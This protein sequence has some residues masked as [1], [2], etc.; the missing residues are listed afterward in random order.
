MNQTIRRLIATFLTTLAGLT[1][2]S[3]AT[4]A[5]ADSC[6]LLRPAYRLTAAAK[7]DDGAAVP[8]HGLLLC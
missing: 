5:S 2:A 1:A 8:L 7:S 6:L 4:L 3:A